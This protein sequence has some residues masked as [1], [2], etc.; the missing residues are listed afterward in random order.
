MLATLAKA[1]G[2]DD[3]CAAAMQKLAGGLRMQQ[4]QQLGGTSATTLTAM[5]VTEITGGGK[6]N[7]VPPSRSK[8]KI[9]TLYMCT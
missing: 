2:A 6:L 7:Q 4:Q 8:S 5:H 9:T 1:F 3:P